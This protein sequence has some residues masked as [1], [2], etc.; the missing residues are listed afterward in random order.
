MS[1]VPTCSGIRPNELIS[2]A[3][4]DGYILL[5]GFLFI[6]FIFTVPG[7]SE[8][9][10]GHKKVHNSSEYPEDSGGEDI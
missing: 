3:Y 8:D 7:Q 9:W 5:I 2:S 10:T 6:L 1:E 4:P